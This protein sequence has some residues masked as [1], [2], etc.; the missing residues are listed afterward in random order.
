MDGF[1]STSTI[2]EA[3]KR[4]AKDSGVRVVVVPRKRGKKYFNHETSTVSTHQ[5]RHTFATRCV[6]QGMNIKALQAIMGHSDYTITENIYV[7]ADTNFTSNE[8]K[9]VEEEL[10]VANLM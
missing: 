8:L 7:S 5:I 1:I 9:K 4:I 10:K 3:F 2:N 6:E